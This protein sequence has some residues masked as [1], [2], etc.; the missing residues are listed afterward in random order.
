MPTGYSE[1]LLDPRLKESGA[2]IATDG[3]LRTWLENPA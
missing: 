1:E 3:E 2:V